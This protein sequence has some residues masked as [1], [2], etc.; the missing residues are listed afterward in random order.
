[1]KKG[2]FTIK[3]V[4]HRDRRR[5]VNSFFFKATP[6]NTF[7]NYPNDIYEQEADAMDDRVMRM[8]ANENIFFQPSTNSIQ[9]KCEHCEEE[10]KLQ[11]KEFFPG[12]MNLSTANRKLY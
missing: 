2:T 4:V 5:N 10:E 3:N 1:M 12:E 6:A 11:R 7:I 9:R 8:P